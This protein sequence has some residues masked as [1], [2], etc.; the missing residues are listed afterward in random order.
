MAKV[1]SAKVEA[2]KAEQLEAPIKT[3]QTCVVNDCFGLKGPGQTYV[4]VKHIRAS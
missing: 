3:E 2:K 4:C 1:I